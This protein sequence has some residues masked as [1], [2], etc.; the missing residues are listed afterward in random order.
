[1]AT[2]PSRRHMIAAVAGSGLLTSCAALAH[3]LQPAAEAAGPALLSC[4]SDVRAHTTFFGAGR[5][6][7]PNAALELPARGHD[8]AWHPAADGS[9]VVVARRPGS[10]LVRW[11]VAS[12][13]ELARFE[14]DDESRFEG[15]LAFS[16]DARLLYTT[17]T[18]LI[19]GDGRIGVFDALNLA[20]VDAWPC[21][22]IGPHAIKHLRD[23]RLAVANG[24]ILTL[25]ETGR[26]KHNIGSMDP[27]LSVIDPHSG[28]LLTQHRLPDAFMSV[29]H[30]AQSRSGQIA[31]ALQNEGALARPL[32]ALLDGERLRYGDAD[33]SLIERCGRYAGDITAI[34]E[35]FAVSCTTAGLTALWSSDGSPGPALSSPKVCALSTH[36]GR[37]LATAE[38]GDIWEFDIA[39]AG[40]GDAHSATSPPLLRAH[41]KVAVTLD[42]H[43]CSAV[44]LAG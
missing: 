11:H 5:L 24:G 43:A 34:G 2:D 30:I 19:T 33:A 21:G 16:A 42:N 23:G 29:R 7:K 1:M 39:A 15:H 38:G 44:P 20:R 31:V 35:H 3:A 40:S 41:Q 14:T 22:G 17:E 6:D 10:F 18:D 8:I 37:L 36:Y 26:I 13:T 4:W 12:G 25:P 9:A 32:F 27:S 28:R